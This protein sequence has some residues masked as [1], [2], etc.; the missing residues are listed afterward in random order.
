MR[1]CVCVLPVYIYML[2]IV[3]ALST[4][5]LHVGVESVV[6]RPYTES[7]DYSLLPPIQGVDSVRCPGLF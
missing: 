3:S 7:Q 5:R 2:M 4:C 1:A 6:G